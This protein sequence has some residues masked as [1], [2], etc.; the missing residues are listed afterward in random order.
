MKLK[1]SA[2]LAVIFM[3]SF[4]WASPPDSRYFHSGDGKL[5]ISGKGGSFNGRYRLP[6]GTY[7]ENSLRLINRAIGGA[8]G[9]PATEISPRLIEF[10][11]YL[12][13]NL[14]SGAK[15][16]VASGYRSPTY[17]TKLRANGKLAAKASLHQYGMASDIRIDGVSSEQVWNHIKDLGFGG[18]GFY[19][20]GLVH[21]DVGPARSWDETTSGVGTD[22]SENN[23]LI[24]LV[25]DKDIYVAGEPITLRF[26]RMT[27]FPIGVSKIF[28]L[29]EKS[30]NGWKE[31]ARFEP[32]MK[33]GGGAC[34]Q[35]SDIP[36]MAG[37]SWRLPNEL[38]PA[39]HRVRAAFCEISYEGMPA[40]IATPE[41]E[42]RAK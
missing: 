3:S 11:D 25:P 9:N 22:I 39:R 28:Y 27:A 17:N 15:I 5:A 34:V 30:A 10:F 31:V 29:E 42:V 8:Y 38:S 14:G 37:I 18:A 36:S 16:T 7:D 4:V 12:Q 20:G 2:L 13:D 32:K 35:F 33:N 1:L 41:F 21:V 26:T 6:G 23:K 40:D 19:H 24:D